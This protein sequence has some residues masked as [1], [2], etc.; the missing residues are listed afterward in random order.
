MNVVTTTP[1]AACERNTHTLTKA[2]EEV[3]MWLSTMPAMAGRREAIEK[4][5]KL[6]A[7][8]DQ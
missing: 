4:G 2:S 8:I 6:L 5:K 3:A 1:M 7:E